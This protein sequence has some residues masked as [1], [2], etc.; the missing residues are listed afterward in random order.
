VLGLSDVAADAAT[1]VEAI[2]A[3]AFRWQGGDPGATALTKDLDARLILGSLWGEQLI[4]QFE[5]EWLK[6]TFHGDQEFVAFGVFSKDRAMG[7]YPLDFMLHALSDR[8]V[9]VT[10]MLSFNMLRARSLPALEPNG[11]VNLLDRV[12]RIVPRRS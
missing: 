12:R 10:V 3:F 8:G 1:V 7:I 2:D 4:R 6:I 11:Y 5:W 9:D